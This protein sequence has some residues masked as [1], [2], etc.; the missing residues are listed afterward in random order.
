MPVAV[1]SLAFLAGLWACL[2]LILLLAALEP[3][4]V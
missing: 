4:H 2:G 3:R 1:P